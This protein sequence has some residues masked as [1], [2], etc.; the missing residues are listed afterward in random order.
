MYEGN[1][2]NCSPI[3]N[4]FGALLPLVVPEPLADDVCDVDRLEPFDVEAASD[5]GGSFGFILNVSNKTF[6]VLKQMHLQ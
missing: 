2:I 3:L 1:P 4:H 6:K 5:I